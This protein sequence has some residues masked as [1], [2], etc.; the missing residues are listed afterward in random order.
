MSQRR[1]SGNICHLEAGCLWILSVITTSKID[2]LTQIPGRIN[3][4]DALTNGVTR[5]DLERHLRAM[6]LY[7]GFG[8]ASEIPN[9]VVVEQTA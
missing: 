9:A 1:G 3:P 8:R 5:D 4:S 6:P 7:V 2:E